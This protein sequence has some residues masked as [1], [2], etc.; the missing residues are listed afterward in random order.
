[1]KTILDEARI[2]IE[3]VEDDI[4]KL[5]SPDIPTLFKNQIHTI[6]V[7]DTLTILLSNLIVETVEDVDIR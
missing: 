4:F 1:M 5:S 2:V 7:K 6:N 3:R